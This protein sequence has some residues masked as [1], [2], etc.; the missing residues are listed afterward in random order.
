MNCP[1]FLISVLQTINKFNGWQRIWFF[2]SLLLLLIFSFFYSQAIENPL[3]GFE[4][5]EDA[6]KE[7]KRKESTIKNK[8]HECE[9]ARSNY[10]NF[11]ST[12]GILEKDVIDKE[13]IIYDLNKKIAETTKEIN[14][15]K[16]NINNQQYKVVRKWYDEEVK[17]LS[18]DKKR[19]IVIDYA[20]EVQKET[21]ILMK[22]EKILI[23]K[24]NEYKAKIIEL[25][26]NINNIKSNIKKAEV[27]EEIEKSYLSRKIDSCVE[28]EN[29]LYRAKNHLKM[30]QGR[31]LVPIW[32]F[33]WLTVKYLF[34]YL[35]SISFLYALGYGLAWIRRGFKSG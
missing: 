19:E 29:E 6:R 9:T 17:Y 35:T 15:L 3:Y 14:Q 32:E 5:L 7:V 27:L 33:L 31:K 16:K 22:K 34:S 18:L 26:N 21:D 13:L 8:K 28:T 24:I 20:K 23:N 30:Q 25:K 11:S 4:L 1:K 10:L 12:Q 2:S